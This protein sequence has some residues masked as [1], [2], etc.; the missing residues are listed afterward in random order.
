MEPSYRR[1]SASEVRK[2]LA[3]ALEDG[4]DA[5]SSQLV[6]N[7]IAPDYRCLCLGDACVADLVAGLH[8][9]RS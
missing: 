8:E 4:R 5:Y 2:V 1:L 3:S 6:V 7:E 9:F